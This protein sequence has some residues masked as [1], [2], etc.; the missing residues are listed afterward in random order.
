M[1][2]RI[3][4]KTA[5]MIEAANADLANRPMTSQGMHDCCEVMKGHMAAMEAMDA[6]A[7]S[8]TVMPIGPMTIEMEAMVAAGKIG[9]GPMAPPKRSKK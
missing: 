5:L 9:I 4:E 6:R 1:S 2:E 7:S 8:V 3:R